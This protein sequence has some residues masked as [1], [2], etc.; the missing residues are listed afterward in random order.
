MRYILV[1]SAMLLTGCAADAPSGTPVAWRAAP[2]T[3][4]EWCQQA[5]DLMGEGLNPGQQ[6]IL[7][8]KMRNMGCMEAHRP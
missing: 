5:T 4:A 7:T 8:E 6:A 1:A 3:T 2:T